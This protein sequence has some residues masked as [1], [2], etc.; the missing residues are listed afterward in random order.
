MQNKALWD[1]KEGRSQS[2]DAKGEEGIIWWDGL[3]RNIQEGE[4]LDKMIA[5]MIHQNEN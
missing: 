4:M 5:R 3:W 1:E 2:D